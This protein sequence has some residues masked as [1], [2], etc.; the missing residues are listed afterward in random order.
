MCG[1]LNHDLTFDN[2]FSIFFSPDGLSWL[3][4]FCDCVCS[5]HFV[6]GKKSNEESSSSWIPRI[7]PSVY[8]CKKLTMYSL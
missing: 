4:K 1:N 7:F 3:L 2:C 8:M 5:E 6:G